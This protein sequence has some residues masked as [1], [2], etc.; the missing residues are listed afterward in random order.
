LQRHGAGRNGS[1]F[2]EFVEQVEGHYGADLSWVS[3][4]QSGGEPQ[5]TTMQR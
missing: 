4:R 5:D 1:D 2:I 3:P